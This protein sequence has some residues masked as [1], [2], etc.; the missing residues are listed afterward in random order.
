MHD[1]TLMTKTSPI[2]AAGARSEEPRVQRLIQRRASWSR[3]VKKTRTLQTEEA[4]TQMRNQ[5]TTAAAAAGVGPSRHVYF[6][7]VGLQ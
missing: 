4:E 7:Y 5:V 3:Q 2:I 6:A 1:N